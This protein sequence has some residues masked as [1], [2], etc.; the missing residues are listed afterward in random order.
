MAEKEEYIIEECRF[1]GNK[2]K[3]DIVGSHNIDQEIEHYDEE[4][5]EEVAEWMSCTTW[6]LLKCCVCENISLGSVYVDRA[7]VSRGLEYSSIVYPMKTYD[8]NHMPKEIY[9]AYEV[10]LKARYLDGALCL[11]SLRRTL[12][13]ICKQQGENN[14][15]LVVKIQ[16]LAN[17]GVLPP[18][19]KDA[20]DI[21]RKLGNEAAHG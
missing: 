4:V 9:N 14:G 3:L 17:K 18:V 13:I 11:L 1:C 12:E 21:L 19:L 10:A 16:N 20:S 7:L 15:N 5:N 8:S 2:T 6:F